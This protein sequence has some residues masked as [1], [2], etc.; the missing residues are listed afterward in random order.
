MKKIC[1]VVCLLAWG[2]L[3]AGS[4]RSDLAGEFP[5]GVYWGWES[6]A[7][8]A[9]KAGL[10]STNYVDRMLGLMKD[11]NCDAVW[12][13]NGP[14]KP[15]GPEFLRLCERHGVRALLNTDLVGFFYNGY[16]GDPESMKRAAERT[17]GRL[18]SFPSLM[19]YVLKD[20]PLVC[21]VQQVDY[22]YALMKDRDPYRR[23]SVVVAMTPDVQTYV[24]DTSLPVL[25]CDI[26][27]FGGDR[28][29]AIPNPSRVSMRQ[30]RQ[31]LRN[32]VLSAVHGG[33]TAWVM[34]MAFGDTWGPNYWDAEGRHWAEP[35]AYCHWRMPTCAE[36]RWQ[37][38]EAVRTGAKG[39][40][41][42]YLENARRF[43]EESIR[44]GGEDHAR[45]LKAVSYAENYRKGVGDVPFEPVRREIERE[46]ALCRPGGV[47]TPQ[48]DALGVCF[49][50][51]SL[52]RDRLVRSRPAA[53]PSFF[54]AEADCATG[55][56]E[57]FG[58][59]G[60]IG[61]LVNDDVK[62]ARTYRIAM[63]ANVVSVRDL[64]GGILELSSAR[65][66]MREFAVTL[67]AGDGML[68]GAEFAA[69]HAGMQL[70]HEDFRRT[71]QKG[72]VDA[73]GTEI[74]PHG[75]FG[76]CAERKLRRTAD[77]GRPAFTVSNVT[78]PKSAVNTFAMNVN[79]RRHAGDLW[80][81]VEGSL[82]NCEIRAVLDGRVEKL[83]TDVQHLK[84]GK[85]SA[86]T[87]TSSAPTKVI[88]SSFSAKDASAD[89]TIPGA[90]AA[91]GGMRL[92]VRLP[93]GITGL[94]FYLGDA[95]SFITDIRMWHAPGP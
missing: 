68:V 27:H 78:N 57:V 52:H 71:R 39:I 89:C 20:E 90:M 95:R 26:Y 12:V 3:S 49:G 66:G 38:W 43:T 22:L 64:N 63:P 10:S 82:E 46:S 74:V 85:S 31:T 69:G 29:R 70:L 35:G 75:S 51:I 93:V 16:D 14:S 2:V 42:F 37:A 4:V 76:I 79:S 81:M 36:T 60:R 30:Y 62:S 94:E 1:L 87:A 67:E 86:G 24:E 13:V 45:Y 88:W 15:D 17:V 23:D 56:L 19:A 28:S 8:N 84:T 92:P 50:R 6:V 48:F 44:E 40:V 83:E 53:F 47:P 73:R 33:K 91:G 59:S 34:P 32:L 61:V 21:S 65:D 7:Y 72:T 80:L 54:C 41:Y 77:F 5:L 11:R 25:C 55:T 9:R 18:A 58:E